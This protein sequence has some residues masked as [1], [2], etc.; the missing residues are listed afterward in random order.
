[1]AKPEAYDMWSWERCQARISTLPGRLGFPEGDTLSFLGLEVNL[2][3]GTVTDTIMGRRLS[4]PPEHLYFLLFRY[5]E[6]RE[7]PLTGKLVSFRQLTGGRL[8]AAVFEK[9]AVF[10]IARKLGDKLERFAIAAK[11]L[12]GQQMPQGDVSFRIKALPLVP[13][14]YVLWQKTEEFPA[15]AQVLMDSSVENYFEAEPL[16]HLAALATERLLTIALKKK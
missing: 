8:Y 9:R 4:K 3:D 7:V 16:T 12:G 13:L 11:Y 2:E 5:A 6:R 14:I 1:M 15:S 10:P